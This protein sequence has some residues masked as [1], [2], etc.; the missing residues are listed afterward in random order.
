MDRHADIQR[1][2]GS[3]PQVDRPTPWQRIW[4]R[5]WALP[6]AIVI[7]ALL[8]AWLLPWLDQHVSTKMPL[9]FEGGPD[10]ARSLLSTIASAMISVTGLVF[11]ITMVVLQLAQSQFTPRLLDSFLQN[12]V[13]QTTLGVFTASFVYAL[14][15]LRTVRGANSGGQDFVPQLSV[16]AAFLLVLAA[17]AMFIAF[18]H[19]ITTSVQ[20]ATVVDRVGG[21]AAE[22]VTEQFGEPED[23]AIGFG[24]T[25]SP[26]EGEA[27]TALVTTGR[28]GTLDH[29]D[30]PRL[31][32]LAR[33]HDVVVHLDVCLGDF[34]ASGQQVGTLWGSD[35]LDRDVIASFDRTLGMARTR[36]MTQDI[37]FG[38]RQLVDIAER[39]LSPSMN[40]PTTAVQVLDELHALLREVALRRSISP[41]IA[42][43]DHVV[44]VVH[45]PPRFADLLDL[46]VDEILHYGKDGI[47]VPRKLEGMLGDLQATARPEHRAPIQAKLAQVRAV[48]DR[49]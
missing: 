20:I 48:C 27:R 45:R 19:N 12:R 34:I 24:A 42:D 22:L 46:A 37:S 11:S 1:R 26:Y 31:V 21:R 35:D 23:E 17:V 41:Y 2:R 8:L 33:K 9:L 5:F 32:A 38:L 47:Q 29:L 39:A 18:I 15:V 25:W 14:A 28:H 44:R 49:P 36:T 13:T 30:L 10:G 6:F 16:S 4:R 3:V 7:G 43:A 40:D